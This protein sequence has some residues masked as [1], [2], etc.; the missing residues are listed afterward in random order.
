MNQKITNTTNSP[1]HI[2]VSDS[3]FGSMQDTIYGAASTDTYNFSY[4]ND[5]ANLSLDDYIGTL[6]NTNYN[7]HDIRVEGDIVIKGKSITDRLETIEKRLAILHP[8]PELEGKWGQLKALGDEYRK[9]EQE[10][11][12]KQNMWD[13]IKK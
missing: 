6:S 5:F 13:I 11:I 9:L 7:Y 10:I 4:T 2:T 12:E 8:N 3:T 1:Y